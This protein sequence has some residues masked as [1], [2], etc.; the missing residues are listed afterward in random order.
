MHQDEEE[1]GKHLRLNQ[2]QRQSLVHKH[3]SSESPKRISRESS[4]IKQQNGS[5][6]KHQEAVGT[7]KPQSKYKPH[8]QHLQSHQY[9][10]SS[11]V[12]KYFHFAE[13]CDSSTAENGNRF[14]KLDAVPE[15]MERFDRQSIDANYS[16]AQ[17][18]GDNVPAIHPANAMNVNSF[19]RRVSDRS[20]VAVVPTDSVS[21]DL[22]KKN[23]ASSPVKISSD[24]NVMPA[25]APIPSSKTSESDPSKNGLLQDPGLEKE[26]FIA[27]EEVY[28]PYCICGF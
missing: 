11:A 5:F 4:F 12:Q 24:K 3:D 17:G 26:N 25:S 2:E 13:V 1:I 7:A 16:V 21:K 6:E 28:L 14:I 8:E 10:Q 23:S 19:S 27:G 9:D 18:V 15:E 22:P 20:S